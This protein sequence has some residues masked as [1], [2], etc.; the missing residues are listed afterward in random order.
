M[1]SPGVKGALRFIA[2]VAI[3]V[4]LVLALAANWE[5]LAQKDVDIHAGPFIFAA[6]LNIIFFVIQAFVFTRFLRLLGPPIP[7]LAS[8]SAWSLSQISKY[9]PGKVMLPIVRVSLCERK[10][11]PKG[12]TVLAIYLELALMIATGAVVF[13]L[14][15]PALSS[16]LE[17]MGLHPLIP[18]SLAILGAIG[19]HPKFL[20]TAANFALRLA[21][22]DPVKIDVPYREI[23]LLGLLL[24]AGW[25]FHGLSAVACVK[26]IGIAPAAGLGT[27]TAFFALAWVLGFLSFLTPGGLGVREGVLALLLGTIYPLEIAIAVS[28]I[29]RLAWS[30]GEAAMAGSL[31][32]ARPRIEAAS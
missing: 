13:L 3:L 31:W 17:G 21:K 27:H 20:N 6:F 24:M 4:F 28:L 19:L 1:I 23:L 15:G 7:L 10:G 12:A 29:S 30:L 18:V 11:V 25:L 32:R 16:S 5:K 2:A 8:F 9:V 22:K 14:C 26:A